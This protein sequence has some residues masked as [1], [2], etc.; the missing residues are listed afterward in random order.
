[1]ILL[2]EIEKAHPD[3]FNILLQ[4]LDEGELTDRFG[5]RV[6]FK[7][8]MIIMTANIGA[9]QLQDF[10][11]GMG[12]ATKSREDEADK[13]SNQVI[14]NALK[15]TFSPEFLNRIDD[16]VIFNSLSKEHIHKII[17]ISLLIC[18]KDC[19]NLISKLSCQMKL[20]ISF[21][22]KALIRNLEQDHFTG[23]FRNMLK[24]RFQNSF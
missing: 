7:N 3:I 5:R 8:S 19:K 9:R 12:F 24:I 14:Q 4:V 1:M 21:Q 16:V 23:L 18:T 2:D 20:K 6:D 17:D 10:G 11:A 22:I 15:K 13:N